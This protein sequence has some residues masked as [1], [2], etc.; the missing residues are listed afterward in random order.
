MQISPKS[1]IEEGFVL[2]RDGNI[3][4]DDDYF[5][6]EYSSSIDLV[7]REI[8]VKTKDGVVAPVTSYII[9]PRETVSLISEQRVNIKPGHIAYVFLKNRLSQNGILALNTGI[10]DGGFNGPISTLV[11]NFSN[12][13]ISLSCLTD[14]NRGVD[15]IHKSFFRVVFHTISLSYEEKENI[16]I[17]NYTY[18]KYRSMKE[19]DLESLPKYFLDPTKQ[20]E[21]MKLEFDQKISEI[22]DINFNKYLSVAG[23][24]AALLIP[25]LF[26]FLPP[27]GKAFSDEIFFSSET[28]A[29]KFLQ[30]EKRIETLDE[31]L[32][33]LLVYKIGA[34]DQENNV[35]VK[36]INAAFQKLETLNRKLDVLAIDKSKNNVE[37]LLNGFIE[38]KKEIN[39]YKS[40]WNQQTSNYLSKQNSVSIDILGKIKSIDTKMV[41]ITK[42]LNLAI[43]NLK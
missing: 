41:L 19:K 8:L 22:K 32:H 38:Y 42:K 30:L 2:D 20:Q 37:V 16:R 14:E 23:F 27:L 33:D 26:I 15:T 7:I 6:H 5:E 3:I 28:N 36:F 10:L 24:L 43:D 40:Q 34:N 18:K 39:S 13:P 17:S 25:V 12:K 1:A 9:K 35:E 4:S 21:N 29:S 11:T 31:K